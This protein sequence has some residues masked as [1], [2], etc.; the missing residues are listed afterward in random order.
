[1]KSIIIKSP[2]LRVVNNSLRDLPCPRR[3]SYWWNLGSLLRLCLGMQL[4]TGLFL[5]IH[6][7]G[8]ASIAFLRVSHIVRDVNFG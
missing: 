2:L 1:M 6:Y 7:G 8:D 5:S 4:I 3:I